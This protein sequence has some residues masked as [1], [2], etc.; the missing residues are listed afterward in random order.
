MRLSPHK[1]HLLGALLLTLG[2][3]G[4]SK[5]K[6]PIDSNPPNPLVTAGGGEVAEDPGLVELTSATSNRFA[7]ADQ[8]SEL[9]VRLRI[10][11]DAL[12]DAP[13]PPIN[14]ML[15]VDTSGSMEG[16]AITNARQAALALVDQLQPGDQFGLVTFH[17][18]AEILVPSTRI[19]EDSLAQVRQRV[20]T[21]RA[22]GTTDL[23][24]GLG[25]ALDQMSAAI[26]HDGI[27]RVVL[28]SDGVPN[29][30][31]P[32][33]GLAQSARNLGVGITALGLG[34]E[35]DETLLSTVAQTSGGKF[36]FIESSTEVAGV[37][38]NEV[39][40]LERVAAANT[41]LSLR[42][43]PGIA[44]NEVIGLP[45]NAAGDGSANVVLGDLVEGEDRDVFV[46]VHVGP[47]KDGAPIELM[48]AAVGFDDPI[49]Q[50][51]RHERSVYVSARSSADQT[52][53]E[54]GRQPAIELSSERARAA[55]AIVQAIALSRAGQLPNARALID[56]AEPRARAEGERL[57]D[58]ELVA[59]ANEMVE[60]RRALPAVQRQ[61][62][63]IAGPLGP[64]GTGGLDG[65]PVPGSEPEPFPE[66][67]PSTVR[68][69][70]NRAMKKLQGRP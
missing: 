48:D 36:H 25:Q 3:S 38:R 13:R 12:A 17:S 30:P 43:G 41:V 9:L 57:G 23:A 2:M 56:Q 69:S 44:I 28:L 70:H 7:P 11:A 63:P 61:P 15:V 40:R 59:Q 4:C 27:N 47:H 32:V 55:A 50:S 31:G 62:A 64:G 51:G 26:R 39:L 45:L 10:S 68:K 34:L 20:K 66:S 58:D 49:N 33:H 1:L 37:F 6:G 21:M 8:A 35:Y 16:E 14:I 29:D 52:E 46:R 19:E 67:A 54:G 53:L 5:H 65:A 24:G 60:L 42:P 18:K 22:R